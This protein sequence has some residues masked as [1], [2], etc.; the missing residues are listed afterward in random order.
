MSSIASCIGGLALWVLLP[1]ALP[2]RAPPI[3]KTYFELLFFGGGG[4]GVDR[5]GGAVLKKRPKHSML[6]IP[7]YGKKIQKKFQKLI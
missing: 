4:G 6:D 1:D 7:I 2:G 5:E 3:I